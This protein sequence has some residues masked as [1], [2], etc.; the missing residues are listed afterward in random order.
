[1]EEVRQREV[2]AIAAGK[3]GDFTRAIQIWEQILEAYPRW[4]LGYAHYNLADCYTCVG[5]IDRAIEAYHQAIALSPDDPMFT[6]ALAS[7]LEARRLGH[8]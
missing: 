7:V 3:E 1:M 4:E 2:E 5:Q 6:E 8:I